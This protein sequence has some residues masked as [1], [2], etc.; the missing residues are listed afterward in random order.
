MSVG[1]DRT[2]LVYAEII[3]DEAEVVKLRNYLNDRGIAFKE[4]TDDYNTIDGF[5]MFTFFMNGAELLEA[6]KE[7]DALFYH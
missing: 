5:H 2:E 6:N 1:F 3:E 4:E 7:I